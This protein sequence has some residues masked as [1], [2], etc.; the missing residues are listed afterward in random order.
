MDTIRVPEQLGNLLRT[1]RQQRDLTQVDVARQLGISAQAV[2]KL[3]KNAGRASFE[4]IHRL[5][6]LLDLEIT[7]QP[8]Q[9]PGVSESLPDT[10]W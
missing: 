1:A 3:E 4:R 9:S 5:C 7:L 8:R 10:E 6:L 2:S